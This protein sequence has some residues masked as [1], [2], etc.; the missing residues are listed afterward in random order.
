[1][2]KN[3]LHEELERRLSEGPATFRLHAQIGADGDD[4]TD[5]TTPWPEER[6]FVELGTMTLTAYT[7][8]ACG[9]MIFD[10]G[11]LAPGIEPSDDPILKA[12]SPA[13]SVSFAR[14]S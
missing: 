13:Y 10:P 1:L 14:R 12:R 9:S 11:R 4:P 7:G 8:G 5:P 2:G 3:Y 6:D